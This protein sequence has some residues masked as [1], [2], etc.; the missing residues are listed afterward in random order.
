M[1]D[2]KVEV[3][4]GIYAR[5][6][7]PKDV[8]ADL[9]QWARVDQDFSQPL[10]FW[11]KPLSFDFSFISSYFREF[12]IGNPWHFREANDQNTWL[13][14]RYFPEEAPPI[15]KELDFVGAE[16]NALDDTLHQVRVVLEGY[17]RTRDV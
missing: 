6:E 15:E 8:M 5:M 12:E 1:S 2:Q 13:R 11:S 9:A 14:A 17:S 16:H 4:K 7:E 10:R 3:L